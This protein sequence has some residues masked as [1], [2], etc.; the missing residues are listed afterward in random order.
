MQVN[1]PDAP[2]WSRIYEVAAG[3]G[4]YIT[5]QQA[6]EAGYSLPLLTHHVKQGRLQRVRR[7]V[8]RL[9]HYPAGEHEDLIVLWLWSEQAGVFSHETA[10]L[11]HDLS[12]ALPAVYHLT[13]P[14]AWSHRRL[15][16]PEGVRL[17]Y[18]DVG[19]TER[20]WVGGVPITSPLRTLVDCMAAHVSP[21][22]I[23]TARR[24]LLRRGLAS[25]AELKNMKGHSH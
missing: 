11:L 3:Q 12:D 1:R 17:Y 10:L 6:Q 4:G 24:Q 20:T 22:F 7:G 8:Y 25:A 19:E 14:A 13:L 5:T 23:H 9:T 21:E 16:V 2:S 18:A 15:R